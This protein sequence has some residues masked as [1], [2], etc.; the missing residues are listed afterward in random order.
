MKMNEIIF[1]IINRVIDDSHIHWIVEYD[2]SKKLL[3][4][5]TTPKKSLDVVEIKLVVDK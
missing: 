1:E 3:N 2:D 4:I 5:T